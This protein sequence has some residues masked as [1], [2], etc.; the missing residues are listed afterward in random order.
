VQLIVEIDALVREQ[1]EPAF[2]LGVPGDGECLKSTAGQLEQVLLQRIEAEGVLY[3]EIGPLAI[4]AVGIDPVAAIALEKSGFG[5]AMRK[6]DAGEVA[7]HIRR[8]RLLHRAIMMRAGP[9][10]V[11]GR[12][13]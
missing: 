11:L 12:V 3:S 4:R 9:R 7:Q 6:A 1:I 5:L 8:V 10:L 13:T 2:A